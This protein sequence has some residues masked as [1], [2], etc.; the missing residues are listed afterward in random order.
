MALPSAAD[1]SAGRLAQLVRALPSHGRGQSFKSFVAHHFTFNLNIL[2]LIMALNQKVARNVLNWWLHKSAKET[3][4]FWR[5]RKAPLAKVRYWAYTYVSKS[6][7]KYP[8]IEC[9]L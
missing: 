6:L 7:G 4:P 8:D 2:T 9:I 5:K 3:P 1:A